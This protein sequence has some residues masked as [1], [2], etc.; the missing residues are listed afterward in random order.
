MDINKIKKMRADGSSL[1]EIANT[2]KI[3]RK[4]VEIALV[5]KEAPA[6]KTSAKKATK[7]KKPAKGK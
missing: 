7:T 3:K 5:T 4:E 1:G 2:L 6:V